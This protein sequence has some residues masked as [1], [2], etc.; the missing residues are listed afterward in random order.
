MFFLLISCPAEE[1]QM[2]ELKLCHWL[3][4]EPSGNCRS[5]FAPMGDRFENYRRIGPAASSSQFVFPM[6]FAVMSDGV[7]EGG[8]RIF[9]QL[10]TL[11]FSIN[12][13]ERDNH[14]PAFDGM[15]ALKVATFISELSQS[16]AGWVQEVGCEFVAIEISDVDG[17]ISL[18]FNA[19]DE[20]VLGLERALQLTRAGIEMMAYARGLRLYSY[21]AL[22]VTSLGQSLL[23]GGNEGC[24]I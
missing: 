6:C 17:N 12:R 1:A 5:V 21:V 16:I 13:D 4:W 8:R 14:G 11:R 15:P 7:R 2:K 9:P 20:G 24:V 3:L 10:V 23:K 18:S 19:T 22:D